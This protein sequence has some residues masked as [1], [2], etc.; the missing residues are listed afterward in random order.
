MLITAPAFAEPDWTQILSPSPSVTLPGFNP[1]QTIHWRAD[2]YRSLDE[3][4]L[5][6]KPLFVTFRCLP[7]K[8]CADFDR[9]VLEGGPLLTPL[10]SQFITVRLTDANFMDLRIFPVEGYQDLDLSWWGYFLSPE[11][12]VYS[13]FGGKDETGDSARI[14]P[15]ALANTM[16]RVLDHHADPRRVGWDIDGPRPDLTGQPARPK[17]LPGHDSWLGPNPPPFKTE[18]MHCHMVADILRQPAVDNRTFDKQ[19]DTQVWPYPE[20]VGLTVDRDH[21][22]LVTDVAPGSPAHRAGLR[23]GD[24]LAASQDTKLFGQADFRATLHRAP[25]GDATVRLRYFR[26]KRLRSATLELKDGWRKTELAWRMSIA[27]GVVGAR[28][29]FWPNKGP[30]K[31]FKE[32]QMSIRPWLGRQQ[33]EKPAYEIGFRNGQIITAVDGESPNLFGREFLAWFRFRYDWGDE[34]TFTVL[35]NGQRKNIRFQLQRRN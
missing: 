33:T 14:S 7:C 19:R 4:R 3:A 35:E 18:C 32:N 13:V 31:G 11:A 9:D 6:N 30:R 22:L 17:Q 8:Q 29:P 21:G 34:V 20:N 26:D 27:E 1:S 12:R 10:L 5:T 2:L 28:P 24:T 25:L 15:E 16:K 23:A